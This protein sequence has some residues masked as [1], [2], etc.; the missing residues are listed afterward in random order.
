MPGVQASCQAKRRLQS[1]GGHPPT[2]G[3]QKRLPCT[4]HASVDLGLC[5]VPWIVPRKMRAEQ[6]RAVGSRGENVAGARR[7]QHQL[8]RALK[9]P[10]YE[11]APATGRLVHAKNSTWRTRLECGLGGPPQV[12]ERRRL[13]PGGRPQGDGQPGP[14]RLAAPGPP[15]QAPEPLSVHVTQHA[16]L[17][18][19][20]TQRVVQRLPQPHPCA[21][22]ERPGRRRRVVGEHRRS[23]LDVNRELAAAAPRQRPHRRPVRHRSLAHKRRQPLPRAVVTRVGASAA[24]PRRP[25][26][27]LLP[28]PRPPVA[29][30]PTPRVGDALGA[31]HGVEGASEA[32]RYS[33]GGASA[34]EG[35]G[36]GGGGLGTRRREAEALEG[37]GLHDEATAPRFV[38]HAGRVEGEVRELGV[39]R[40]EGARV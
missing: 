31:A 1:S 38:L 33:S 34:A 18:R 12:A 16:V 37:A 3:N 6:G 11:V 8:L 39:V 15:P 35:R 9:L 29:G 19:G 14:C 2:S 22:A 27:G 32:R 28:V 17:R 40:L 10:H 7:Q 26:N 21:E 4:Q 24:G 13:R 36:E 25:P 20:Q 23:V 5:L 30:G